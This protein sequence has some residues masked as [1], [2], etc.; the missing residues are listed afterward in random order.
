MVVAF[1]VW[2]VPPRR[3]RSPSSHKL[4]RPVGL[5]SDLRSS[6][7]EYY[8]DGVM[9]VTSGLSGKDSVSERK[10]GKRDRAPGA[11]A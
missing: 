4:G 1:F 11:L 9:V 8:A 6:E 7:S 10:R 2:G 5:A 3:G